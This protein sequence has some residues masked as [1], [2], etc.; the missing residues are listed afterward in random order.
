LRLADHRHC[1]EIKA[2]EGLAD[3]E[4]GFGEVPLD[5][6]A[7]TVGD[8]VLGERREEARC[9]PAFLVGLLGELGPYLFDRGQTQIERK[10]STRAVSTG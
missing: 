3:R 8:L 1:F 6:A 9:R 10:S 4:A 7:T 2:V 5:A